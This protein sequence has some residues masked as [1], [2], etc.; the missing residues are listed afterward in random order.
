MSR[1]NHSLF[2]A[3]AL[4]LAGTF[5]CSGSS[6]DGS[7]DVASPGAGRG[8][9]E[10]LE[11]PSSLSISVEDSEAFIG[12]RIL[13]LASGRFTLRADGTETLELSELRIDVGEMTFYGEEPLGTMALRDISVTLAKPATAAASYTGDHSAGSASMKLDLLLD[14]KVVTSDGKVVPLATQRIDDAHVDFGVSTD[15]NGTL[16]VELAGGKEG[17]VLAWSSLEQLDDLSFDL[18]A[19]R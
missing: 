15:E 13:P 7:P 4:A 19:T 16:A 10:M 14:W 3:S 8:V 11:E 9:S 18:R 12:N 2:F 6:A 17:T 1:R 5:G